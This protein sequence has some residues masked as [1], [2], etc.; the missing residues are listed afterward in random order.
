MKTVDETAVSVL[1]KAAGEMMA[2]RGFHVSRE[3]AEEIERDPDWNDPAGTRHH[4]ARLWSDLNR[5]VTAEVGSGLTRD[6][7]D[8][9]E[10]DWAPRIITAEPDEFEQSPD[11]DPYGWL[12]LGRVHQRE[13]G[14]DFSPR[15]ESGTW[16][17]CWEPS[18]AWGSADGIHH[19]YG[20]ITGFVIVTDGNLA[21]AHV[22]RGRRRKGI[23]SKLVAEAVEHHNL[24]RVSG[25]LTPDGAALVSTL[26][27]SS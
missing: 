24:T 14:W 5:S 18:S 27:L 20:V 21:F 10:G 4:I 1:M 12:P 6:V 9:T 26:S 15:R 11:D 3:I 13:A 17:G 23:A 16:I 8:W 7:E 25:P 19:V 2:S 22:V